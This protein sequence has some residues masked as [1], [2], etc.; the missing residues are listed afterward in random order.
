MRW[1]EIKEEWATMTRR[2]RTDWTEEG[3][4]PT[5]ARAARDGPAAPMRSP[6]DNGPPG[7]GPDYGNLPTV[8]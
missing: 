2:I 4:R 8:Q 5:P 7:N 6:A 3:Q 1:D